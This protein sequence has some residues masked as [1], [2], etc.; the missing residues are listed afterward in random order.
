MK[1]K[2]ATGLLV[3]VLFALVT[4]CGAKDDGGNGVASVKSG[5]PTSSS[6]TPK[7]ASLDPADMDKIREFAKCMRD[8]GVDMPDPQE[9]GGVIALGSASSEDEVGMEKMNKANEACKQFLPDGGEFKEPSQEEKDK[10]REQA[11]CM[12]EHGIDMPDPDAEKSGR[13]TTLGSDDTE[14]F[15]EAMKACG[16]GDGGMLAVPAV[17]GNG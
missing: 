11:K 1:A 10:M 14:K 13:G 16:M 7:G 3:P 17:P 15:T 5:S 8:N 9:G 2:L 12:R 6:G 4:G